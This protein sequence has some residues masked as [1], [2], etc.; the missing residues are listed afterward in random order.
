[1]H[2]TNFFRGQSS[3]CQ[4]RRLMNEL[5]VI[6]SFCLRKDFW[7]RH[8]AN[9]AT[10]QKMVVS[11][12]YMFTFSA[13]V[14]GIFLFSTR[15]SKEFE[16]KRGSSKAFRIF[17]T[18]YLL[19]K[20]FPFSSLFHPSKEQQLSKNNYHLCWRRRLSFEEAYFQTSQFVYL[21]H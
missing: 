7:D 11:T 12:I 1:M 5:P 8:R 4:R 18:N 19:T 9:I 15:S 16:E 10:R 17:L 20:G 21:I 14:P 3:S 6:E 13:L 2:A